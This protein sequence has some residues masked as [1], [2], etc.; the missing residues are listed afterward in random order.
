MGGTSNGQPYH[1]WRCLL[2]MA[3]RMGFVIAW[4][5]R[6]SCLT[7][8]RLPRT[9]PKP[10]FKARLHH[11]QHGC[12]PKPARSARECCPCW[13]GRVFGWGVG[14]HSQRYVVRVG[15]NRLRRAGWPRQVRQEGWRKHNQSPVRGCWHAPA[16]GNIH[17][18]GHEIG[19]YSDNCHDCGD[20]GFGLECHT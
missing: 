1:I 13:G 10:P 7:T 16:C 9:P 5:F 17:P 19:T 6:C 18:L 14:V 3:G 20:C 4:P 12:C 15:R 2:F 11:N 8:S